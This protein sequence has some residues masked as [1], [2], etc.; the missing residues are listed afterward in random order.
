M[1]LLYKRKRKAVPL[2]L[3]VIKE[4]RQGVGHRRGDVR[5]EVSV[6]EH[7]SDS[8][9]AGSSWASYNAPVSGLLTLSQHL[10]L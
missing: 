9:E 6:K 8:G 7:P 10:Q 4:S 3:R 5:I 1:S 2:L